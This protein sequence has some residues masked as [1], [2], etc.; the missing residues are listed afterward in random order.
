M[1]TGQQAGLTLER[2]LG[3]LDA[4]SIGLGAIIGAGVFVLIGTAAGLAGPAVFIAVLISGVSATFTALS[5]GDLATRMP[6]AG[7]AYE[8]GHELISPPIGFLMGWLFVF[9][10]QLVG[11]TASLGF[12]RYLESA[13]G[14]P[15]RIGALLSL[16]LV[17]LFN[18]MGARR[19]ALVNDLLVLAKVGALSLFIALGL[20][21]MQPSFFHNFLPN[22]PF[23]VI[24]AASLF[25]F[26]Y[27]GFPRIATTAE[28]IRRPEVNIRRAILISLLASSLL[29]LLTSITA[30]GLMG[31]ES[32]GAS[33][34]PLADA[35]A[36]LGLRGIVEVGAL[37][38]T[39]S[40]VL[41]SVLGQSRVFFAMA[42][43]SEI[44][45]FLS[46]L[47]G[48]FETPVYSVL[49][50]GMIMLALVLSIDITS[51]A[52]LSSFCVLFTHVLVNYS[53]LRMRWNSGEGAT[54]SRA[55][56]LHAVLGLMMSALLLLGMGVGTIA[57]GLLAAVAGLAWYALYVKL[58]REGRSP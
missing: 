34:T 50:S 27:I 52:Y 56:T 58:S 5:F 4:V 39:L 35:S 18:L 6:R 55:H 10:N 12:G 42:R 26:A 44:P 32:L 21:R 13:T 25:Y 9:G 37:L 51:L 45:H 31:Y 3:L 15:F 23:P 11:S 29:Y 17:I 2:E 28:E 43:N 7:G 20:P 8:Y 57:I 36:G 49:L 47:Q 16:S 1:G 30:V 24:Q 14:I 38:A 33:K 41:T 19:S 46:R 48:K 40:V 22:G 53:A 54:A